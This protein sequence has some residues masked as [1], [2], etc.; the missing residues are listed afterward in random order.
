MTLHAIY[1][2]V[3]R[4]WCAV[5]I[6]CG[7]V[8]CGAKQVS[9]Y[10]ITFTDPAEHEFQYRLTIKTFEPNL[11]D[12]AVCPDSRAAVTRENEAAVDLAQSL[13]TDLRGPLSTH[14]D[15]RHESGPAIASEI[16]AITLP[17]D[18]TSAHELAASSASYINLR[19]NEESRGK[20]RFVV[21][22]DSNALTGGFNSHDRRWS[23]V[24][25]L[26]GYRR[27]TGWLFLRSEQ[28]RVKMWLGPL[29]DSQ[30]APCGE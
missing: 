19:L 24:A 8:G 9:V 20:H 22:L 13:S 30:C 15:V 29:D 11:H 18:G 17:S 3:V 4:I 1:R 27:C 26:D 7:C 6:G 14:F 23:N 25:S 2:F 16:A 10:A 5:I 12:L 28:D 21:T